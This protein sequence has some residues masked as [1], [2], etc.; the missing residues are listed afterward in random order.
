MCCVPRGNSLTP[1]LIYIDY[2]DK[3]SHSP[4][5]PRLSINEKPTHACSPVS[6][7][8]LSLVRWIEFA[9]LSFLRGHEKE[10]Y[11]LGCVTR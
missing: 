6:C 3:R 8:V 1:V 11:M 4:A 5:C 9:Y 10:S 7:D 2:N